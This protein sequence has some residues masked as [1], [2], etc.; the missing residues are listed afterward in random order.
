MCCTSEVSILFSRDSI[1]TQEQGQVMFT[2]DKCHLREMWLL[3]IF[4]RL[5]ERA[6]NPNSRKRIQMTF[7][8][9]L[10][11]IYLFFFFN[12]WPVRSGCIP[13]NQEWIHQS[14]HGFTTIQM[15][16]GKEDLWLLLS[17]P[18]FPGTS[19]LWITPVRSRATIKWVK[20]GDIFSARRCKQT[21][22]NTKGGKQSWH[23]WALLHVAF[24]T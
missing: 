18:P 4:L 15:L 16:L 22:K 9:L 8:Q 23:R 5:P 1:H 6:Q 17:Y 21:N 12:N 11:F 3:W 10:H 14:Q 20:H 2:P 24:H 7:W 19:S 13:I